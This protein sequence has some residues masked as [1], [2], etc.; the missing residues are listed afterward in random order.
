MGVVTYPFMFE[1]RQRGTQAV[2][3]IEELRDA[4]DSVIIIPNDR[5]ALGDHAL[6]DHH[7]PQQAGLQHGAGHAEGGGGAGRRPMMQP[8]GGCSSRRSFRLTGTSPKSGAGTG[9]GN[10][11]PPPHS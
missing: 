9:T 3:G 4:V 7:P 5:W 8:T 2:R 11:P 1:G 10:P 6:G